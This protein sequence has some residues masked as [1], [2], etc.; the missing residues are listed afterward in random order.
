M[1]RGFDPA[2][3]DLRGPVRYMLWL[4][5]CQRRRALLG[6]FYGSFWMVS[7]AVPPLLIARAIDGGLEKGDASAV[8]TWALALLAVGVLN[9]WL[10]I[11]RHRTMTRIRMEALFGTNRVVIEQVKRL[12]ADLDRRVS[13][14]ELATIGVAD[15]VIT[16]AALTVTGPGVGAVVSYI[17]VG[18]LVADV[19]VLLA[20][21]VLLGVPALA[22]LVGPLLGRLLGAQDSYRDDQSRISAQL[23]DVVEGLRV[24][25]SFGGKRRHAS[26]FRDQ[27]A[28]LRDRGYE[29]AAVTSWISGLAVGLPAVFLAGVTWLAARLASEGTITTGELVAVYGYV[30]ML[31][32]PVSSLIEGADQLS[33]AMVSARRI[34]GFL[35]AEPM[36]ASGRG[37]VPGPAHQA[38][39]VDPASGVRVEPGRFTALVSSRPGTSVAVIE[40]LG[41]LVD[42]DATWAATRLTSIPLEEI[43]ERILVADHEAHLFA[44]TLRRV[45]QGNTDADDR[46]IEDA[47]H[48]AAAEDVVQALPHGLD[49]IIDERARNLSGGQRQRVRLARALVADPEVLLAVEPTSSLDA[50]TEA[51]VGERLR[52]SRAGRTTVVTTTS[53]LIL[54]QADVVLFLVDGVVAAAGTHEALLAA[55][56]EYRRLVSRGDEPDLATGPSAVA[57]L[58]RGVPT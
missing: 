19:S 6:A 4:V 8:W 38:E 46:A 37:A 58:D 40:R 1:A 42:S 36:R 50:F 15:I 54:A 48:V 23:I 56:G 43:R 34:V 26:R 16:S 32:I 13:A 12:G 10:A 22:I 33:R 28:R 7:L 47:I 51:I 57:V 55:G 18:F 41:R 49:S 31:V 25:N 9:A 27:S 53:T 17:V 29:V 3:P 5:R 14:G 21:V 39:L 30:A 24:L 11:G 52:A 44:G 35:G 20:V 45:L 2:E